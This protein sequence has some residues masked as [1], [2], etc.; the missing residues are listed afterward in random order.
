MLSSPVQTST[1]YHDRVSAF[2]KV[3]K[4]ALPCTWN[5]P[6]E[7]AFTAGA[8]APSAPAKV[9]RL[10]PVAVLLVVLLAFCGV[11][12]GLPVELLGGGVPLEPLPG[13]GGGV[14]VEFLAG[15]GV[16]VEFLA[17]GGVAFL[18]GGGGGVPVEL[19]GGG[20]GVLAEFLPGGGA[21]AAGFALLL[22]WQKGMVFA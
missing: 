8:G 21:T 7:S 1:T 3:L 16:P 12:A 14:P 19:F 6:F 5:C 18:A 9:C 13:G 4:F 20:G 22:F 11:H 17:G 2:C 10:F 15:G